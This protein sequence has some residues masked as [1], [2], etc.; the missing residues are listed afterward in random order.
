MQKI[1][2]RFKTFAI[3]RPV[4]T[5]FRASVPLIAAAIALTACGIDKAQEPFEDAPRGQTNTDRADTLT[6]PDGFSNVATKCDHGNRVYVVFKG[7]AP[8]GAID[9]VE[10]DPSCR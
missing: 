3:E 1:W 6:F 9:V 4:A 7:D 8:Y 10:Q 5:F 2:N